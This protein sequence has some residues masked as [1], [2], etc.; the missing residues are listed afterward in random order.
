MNLK[1]KI[2]EYETR[3]D[4][5]FSA[6]YDILNFYKTLESEMVA[7]HEQGLDIKPKLKTRNELNVYLANTEPFEIE[8]TDFYDFNC[9]DPND[10]SVSVEK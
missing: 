4:G 8:E 9:V 6:Y 3:V 7:D 2:Y 1:Q 10:T 5:D